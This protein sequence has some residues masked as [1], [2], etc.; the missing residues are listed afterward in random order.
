M[1]AKWAWPIVV[2]AIAIVVLGL[3]AWKE[4][5]F[6]DKSTTTGRVNAGNGG[7]NVG[8]DR[9]SPQSRG[10]NGP[11]NPRCNPC[12]PGFGHYGRDP[13]RPCWCTRS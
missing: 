2:G 3:M 8:S 13:Q 9:P 7:G 11:H 12:G 6:F 10:S 1:D 4:V 5:G